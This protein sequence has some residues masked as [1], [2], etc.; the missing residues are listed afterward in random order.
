MPMRLQ[1]DG[2]PSAT[3]CADRD[4]VQGSASRGC[5]DDVRVVTK[6]D[7][8]YWERADTAEQARA[9]IVIADALPRPRS[10]GPRD[11]L[12]ARGRCDPRSGA[13]CCAGPARRRRCTFGGCLRPPPTAP[14]TG[15][16]PSGSVGRPAR[17]RRGVRAVHRE[18]QPHARRASDDGST[19][20]EWRRTVT[21]V[22]SASLGR[23]VR[24]PECNRWATWA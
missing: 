7:A 23:A 14:G 18:A 15:R 8:R 21:L 3:R 17:R 22:I 24:Q 5:A 10:S 16:G 2:W 20:Y 4:H 13:R 12:R 19:D 9:R 11:P 1:R 6:V